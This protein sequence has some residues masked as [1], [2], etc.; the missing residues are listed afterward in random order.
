[1][2]EKAPA[3]SRLSLRSTVPSEM[4]VIAIM[5]IILSDIIRVYIPL[6]FDLAQV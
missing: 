4:G 1:M 2:G 6:F 3:T 5:G